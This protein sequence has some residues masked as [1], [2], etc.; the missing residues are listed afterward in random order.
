MTGYAGVRN[1]SGVSEDA[2]RRYVPSLFGAE[3]HE[4][5]SDRYTYIPTWDVLSKM[6]E[7]GFVI[8]SAQQARVRDASRREFTKHLVRLRHTSSL[9]KAAVVGDSVFELLLKNSHDGSSLYELMGGFF[10]F[11]CANGMVVGENTFAPVKVKHI[12][13]IVDN[14]IDASYSVIEEV[15]R[16]TA[17]V[18]RWKQIQLTTDEQAIF[19]EEAGK[20]RFDVESASQ[21]PISCGRMLA[22]RRSDDAHSD[23]WHT[24]NRVQENLTK[25]GMQ[26]RR[27]DS[28]GRASYRAVRAIKGIDQ[29]LKLN[30]ALWTLAEKMAELKGAA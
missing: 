13:N 4:S 24:F 15:P 11:V 8:T 29:D 26:G 25:G 28:D 1:N 20:L 17:N 5:R 27:I 18:E 16:I 12:G 2:L 14:V 6:Q 23:L 22:A 19:A 9:G 7:K 30:K 3:A 21:L 10:R